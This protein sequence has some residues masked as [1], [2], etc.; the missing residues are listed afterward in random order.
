MNGR[1]NAHRAGLQGTERGTW[2]LD[3]WGVSLLKGRACC[4][5]TA[6]WVISFLLSL[7]EF[8]GTQERRLISFESE[9]W[10]LEA[11]G[12]NLGPDSCWY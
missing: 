12:T 6:V 8:L 5:G 10:V 1:I 3:I 2:M 4:K 9:L 11:I 7:Q